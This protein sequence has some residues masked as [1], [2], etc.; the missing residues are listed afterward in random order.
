MFIR[1]RDSHPRSLLKALSWRIAGSL[2][3][4]VLSFIFTRSLK[5][6]GSIAI[7]EMFTKMAL[8]YF[9]ERL[10][11]AIPWHQRS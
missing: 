11:A 5:L 9:H 4:F 2:D 8:Y 6:A 7:T 1:T 10:W 3:T